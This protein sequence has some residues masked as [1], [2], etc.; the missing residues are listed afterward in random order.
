[1]AAADRAVRSGSLPD[2]AAPADVRA[3]LLHV[4]REIA[5]SRWSGVGLF[6]AAAAAWAA[7]LRPSVVGTGVWWLG[8]AGCLAFAGVF[9]VAARLRTRRVDRLLAELDAPRG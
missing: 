6:G 8:L 5:R 3:G 2:D 1:M 7:L 9:V 4:K